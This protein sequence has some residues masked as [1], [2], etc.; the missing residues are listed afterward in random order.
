MCISVVEHVLSVCKV[1]GSIPS[2]KGKKEGRKR[3]RKER[4]EEE[5]KEGKRE[6]G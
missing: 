1:L 2:M 6:T 3:E 4:R 5:R